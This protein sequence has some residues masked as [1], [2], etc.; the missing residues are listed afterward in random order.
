M[1]G[2]TVLERVREIVGALDGVGS[3]AKRALYAAVPA[4]ALATSGCIAAYGMPFAS[5]DLDGTVVSAE[6]GDP[7]QGIELQFGWDEVTSLTDADGAWALAGDDGA[8]GSPAMA[9]VT[10][11]D[12]DGAANGAYQ[13]AEVDVPVTRTGEGSGDW[14]EGSFAAHGVVIELEPL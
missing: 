1:N 10:V 3:L 13:D 6:S 8:P 4:A 5:Y 7:I 2:K 12:V 14:D 11:R 9:H